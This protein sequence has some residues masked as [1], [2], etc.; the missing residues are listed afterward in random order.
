VIAGARSSGGGGRGPLA[1]EATT[2]TV[3]EAFER[4]EG[5]FIVPVNHLRGA[6]GFGCDLLS[7]ASAEVRDAALRDRFINEADILRYLEVKGR[8]SRTGEVELT[9]N[10][11]RAARRLRA[12]YWI[13]RIYV[14]PQRERHYEVAVLSDPLNST[15]VQMVTRFDL[16]EGSGAAWFAMV[17]TADDEMTEIDES[18][19]AADWVAAGCE[20][21][22]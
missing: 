7:V 5:R 14:D 2:F 17:E 19:T 11:L 18:E 1:T 15:A 9:D 3:V 13:Y 6:E 12:Q 4:A 16:A 8:T 22:R 10:E 21:N 20:S